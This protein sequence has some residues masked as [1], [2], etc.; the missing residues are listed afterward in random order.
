MSFFGLLNNTCTFYT[1]TAS[2]DNTTG[3]QVFTETKIAEGVKCTLQYSGG[4]LDRNSRLAQADN[5]YRLY[6]LPQSFSITKMG[7]IVEVN[8]QKYRVREVID[9]GGRG[10]FLRL[11][12][13][14][15]SVNA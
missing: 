7:T 10:R 1:R 4:G 3:E 14:R 15:Y 8:G 6:L 13:E 2:A 11:D 9:M 12:L 5:F